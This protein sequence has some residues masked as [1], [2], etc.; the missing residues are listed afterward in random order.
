MC[1]HK[2][3]LWQLAAKAPE[4]SWGKRE[5]LYLNVVGSFVPEAQRDFFFRWSLLPRVR[6][7]S[8]GKAGGKS[9]GAQ[10]CAKRPKGLWLVAKPQVAARGVRGPRTARINPAPSTCIQDSPRAGLR[11]RRGGRRGDAYRRR[12]GDDGIDFPSPLYLTTQD[13]HRRADATPTVFR[14]KGSRPG[15]ARI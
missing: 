13:R 6:A 14:H 12:R 10:F 7:G 9:G 1:V 3:R 11:A 15:D 5:A 4:A 2:G 8:N